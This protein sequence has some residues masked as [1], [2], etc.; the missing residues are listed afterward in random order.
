LTQQ[1]EYEILKGNFFIIIH[2]ILFISLTCFLGTDMARER[3]I[4]EGG[5]RAS[6]IFIINI[7]KANSEAPPPIHDS[8]GWPLARGA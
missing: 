5:D 6:I 4:M 7:L 3:K 1:I 8:E 2:V